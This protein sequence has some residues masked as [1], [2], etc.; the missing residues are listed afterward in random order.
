[1]ARKEKRYHY[2][3]KTTCKITN[4]FYVGMHSTDNLEDG[5]M[6]SGKRL[7][8][9]IHKH[10]KENHNV[11]ILEFLLNRCSL[12]LREAEIVN[13]Q[14][15]QDPLCMNLQLGGEGGFSSEEHREKNLK[16]FQ[17]AGSKKQKELWNTNSEWRKAQSEL[18]K[19]I[20]QNLS[21]ESFDKM[22]SGLTFTDKQHSD[23]SKQKIRE[24][25]SQRVG[26]KNSQYGTCWITNGSEN[27]KIKKTET[28]PDGWKLGRK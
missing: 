11:E 15:L 28:L 21:K 7:G 12:K 27:K 20:I 1:M 4:K 6:G 16:A 5:Y 18:R 23:E 17:E 24:K 22:I 13:E 26:D 25:A 10:G 3:Y 9:S 19:T 14:F 2:I 8:Y